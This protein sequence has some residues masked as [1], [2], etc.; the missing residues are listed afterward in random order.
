M[1]DSKQNKMLFAILVASLVLSLV[2]I[3]PFGVGTVSGAEVIVKYY[4]C[5]GLFV[6]LSVFGLVL[7]YKYFEP[8]NKYLTLVTNLPL[9]SGLV[10]LVF[11]TLTMVLRNAVLLNASVKLLLL[12]CL[13]V[14]FVLLLAY[15]IS[16]TSLHAKFEKKNMIVCD[17]VQYLVFVAFVVVLAILANKLVGAEVV[18]VSPFFIVFVALA[19]L[20][21]RAL[22]FL[23]AAK[24][25]VKE[26]KYEVMSAEE[27]IKDW[28]KYRDDLNKQAQD[29][30]LR[31]VYGYSKETLDI[32][33]D[34]V[35]KAVDRVVELPYEVEKIVEVEKVVEVEKI[36]EKEIE[37]EKV[38]E[39]PVDRIVEVPV[40]DPEAEKRAA[41]LEKEVARLT[42][43][44][45]NVV[46]ERL[47]LAALEKE[48]LAKEEELKA[49][50]EEMVEKEYTLAEA[51]KAVLEAKEAAEAAK[52]SAERA[53]AAAEAAKS[54]AEEAAEDAEEALEEKEEFRR[55][56]EESYAEKERLAV[57]QAE[58][59]ALERAEREAAER[60]AKLIAEHKEAAES[61]LQK[62]AAEK[63]AIEAEHAR[64]SAENARIA[65]E[66]ELKNAP[67][68]VKEKVQKVLVP[69]YDD[70]IKYANAIPG[71]E[72][73]EIKPGFH[74]LFKDNKLFLVTQ[75]TYNDYR[76]TFLCEHDEAIKLIVN[77]PRDFVK[78][79]SPKGENWFKFV[80]RG[81]AEAYSESFIY[82][83]VDRSLEMLNILEQRKLEAKEEAKRLKAEARAREKE[84]Q[85]EIAN[86]AA[87][88]KKLREEAEAG[89][90]EPVVEEVAPVVEPV[91]DAE[92]VKAEKSAEDLLAAINAATEALNEATEALQDV[93]EAA[94]E[95]EII[96]TVEETPVVE[97]AP[98]VEEK[99]APKP[100]KSAEEK[101]KEKEKAKAKAAAEKAK[102][103][104]KLAK[105]K[106]A[107]KAKAKAAAE[108]QKEK[109]KLAAQKAKEKEKA[110][111]AA[112]KQ[113][114]KERAAAQKAKEKE[115]A[116]KAKSEEKAA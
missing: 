29:E 21:V 63:E 99:P 81:D 13:V 38:V 35:E 51:T 92:P 64:I 91:V 68:P 12:A 53:L 19:G 73:R 98:V 71:I 96:E 86:K 27:I 14:A 109:E 42:Q 15:E 20:A 6:G 115:A 114:E 69:S 77:S 100:K 61:E 9:I 93:R 3:I 88:A 72:V 32:Q 10:A 113:K 4:V 97:E 102:E 8:A 54:E 104:E 46:E 41:E 1:F 89:K 62:M 39:V 43:E 24:L 11:A 18:A 16:V 49:Q 80:Y 105:Q 48:L 111:L 36:V 60:E 28:Y 30:I 82:D 50:Q 17:V 106:E 75:S 2:V 84:K 59:E 83:I 58:R 103:K 74:R 57:E 112:Q 108:K 37:V 107:E 7:R 101:A 31:S 52:A 65:A 67:K 23:V 33:P 90:A 85:K 87:E 76:I 116:K 66:L 26:E 5:G 47:H 34:V 79:T 22:E 25:A 44:H 70:V 78:A 55:Q 95:Q 56:L 40:G 45:E 94:E 110:K